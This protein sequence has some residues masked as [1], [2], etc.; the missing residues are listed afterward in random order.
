MLLAESLCPDSMQM[1]HEYFEA[2]QPQNSTSITFSL[3][4]LFDR[5]AC[6]RVP[7]KHVQKSPKAWNWKRSEYCAAYVVFLHAERSSTHS[8]FPYQLLPYGYGCGPA[9]DR[10]RFRF[11]SGTAPVQLQFSVGSGIHLL[12]TFSN[13][14][15]SFHIEDMTDIYWSLRK[16]KVE[17]K[18]AS[19]NRRIKEQKRTE[20][21]KETWK[22]SDEDSAAAVESFDNDR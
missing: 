1:R 22:A 21:Y 7:S 15:F 17:H 18:K 9:A 10:L 5:L 6:W 13:P 2:R 16:M 8:S 3:F 4:S 19:H 14:C 12:V 20:T 11:S